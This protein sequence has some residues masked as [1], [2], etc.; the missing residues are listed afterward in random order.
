MHCQCLYQYEFLFARLDFK[1]SRA[2]ALFRAGKAAFRSLDV[3]MT[4]KTSHV[5]H[6][7]GPSDG[8]AYAAS[9]P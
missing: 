1:L 2:L 8:G 3:S 7:T 6:T 4:A 9:V 5:A